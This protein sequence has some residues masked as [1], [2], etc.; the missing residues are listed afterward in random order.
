MDV[1]RPITDQIDESHSVDV[2]MASAWE[3]TN[4]LYEVLWALHENMDAATELDFIAGLRRYA[5]I[6]KG[7][8]NAT[9]SA[10]AGTDFKAHI[11]NGLSKIWKVRYNITIDFKHTIKAEIHKKKTNLFAAPVW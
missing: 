8:A 2:T 3:P 9:C 7:Q 6:N 1:V 10:Y 4:I 5:T 11:D